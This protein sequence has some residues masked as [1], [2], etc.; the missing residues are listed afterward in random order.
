MIKILPNPVSRFLLFFVLTFAWSWSI[1]SLLFLVLPGGMTFSGGRPAEG[2][3]LF[4]L[5]FITGGSGPLVGALILSMLRGRDAVRNLFSQLY[6]LRRPV[7]LVFVLLPCIFALISQ[8]IMRATGHIPPYALHGLLPN[9]V[10]GLMAGAI[11]ELGW[12]GYAQGELSAVFP[13]SLAA[14]IVGIFWSFWHLIGAVWAVGN[15]YRDSFPAFFACAVILPL[16]SFAV[17]MAWLRMKCGNSVTVCI[18][19][20]M[21]VSFASSQFLTNYANSAGTIT[22]YLYYGLLSAAAALALVAADKTMRER[23]ATKTE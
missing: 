17:I 5:F 1:F 7:F 18:L 2:A 11:E 21:S 20:H 14:V 23:A 15:L 10:S 19:F 8:Q 13:P 12:R 4:T 3:P 6:N 9:L 16:T 22:S